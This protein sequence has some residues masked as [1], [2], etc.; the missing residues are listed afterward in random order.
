MRRPNASN[1][2]SIAP[3]VS[4]ARW[5][6]KAVPSR[7]GARAQRDQGVSWR[8]PDPLARAVEE[9]DCR[10]R[11]PDTAESDQQRTAERRQPVAGKRNLLV[12]PRSVGE[13]AA[14]D[15]HERRAALIDAV[16]DAELERRQTDVVDE[17]Q[18]EH[19]R[20]HLGGDVGEQ[21]DDAKQDDG[22]TDAGAE[23]RAEEGAMP[24]GDCL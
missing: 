8:G 16:D 1:G 7:S 3:V 18:R 21:A 19:G 6:P 12:P 2:P 5:I 20:H 10:E 23:R 24:P 9:D 11:T 14:R 15:P 17:V 13:E 22:A 4:S